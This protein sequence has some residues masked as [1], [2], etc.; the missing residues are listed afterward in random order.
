MKNANGAA[1]FTTPT[2]AVAVSSEAK[3]T[4]ESSFGYAVMAG[5]TRIG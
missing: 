2:D 3:V 4:P 5:I 1:S